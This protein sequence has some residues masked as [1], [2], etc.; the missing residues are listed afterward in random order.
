MP[1]KKG[2]LLLRPILPVSAGL[3]VDDYGE[4]VKERGLGDV[5][6]IAM[7][8]YN[9]KKGFVLGGGANVLLRAMA[10]KAEIV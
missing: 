8:G 2:N 1:L 4:W 5:G 3:N 6:L 7:Y 9:F 10:S